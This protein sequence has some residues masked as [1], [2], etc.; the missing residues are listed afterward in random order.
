MRFS[1]GAFPGVQ[2][3]K[4]VSAVGPHQHESILPFSDVCKGLLDVTR[5]LNLV[6]VHL[7]NDVALLQPGVICGTAW[8]HLLDHRA[9]N[10]MWR[11]KLI[12]QFRTF[13][14]NH[15]IENAQVWIAYP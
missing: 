15:V 11:L 13:S 3:S 12:A 14:L 7:E 6:A 1:L 4:R 9:V 5:R 8:L 2:D 10:V